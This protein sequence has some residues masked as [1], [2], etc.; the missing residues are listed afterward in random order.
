MEP[1]LTPA[2]MAEA[3]RRT[4][5]EGTAFETLVGRAGRAVARAVLDELGGAYGRRVVLACGTGN[6]GADGRVAA[7]ALS[8]R[9]VRCTVLDVA[10]GFDRAVAERAIRRADALVDAMYGTGFRGALEGD[11]AWFAERTATVAVPVV[12]ID[13]PS[14]IDGTTGA[15]AGPVVHATRTV[16]FAAWK[17]G[18]LAE[19]GRTCAG[20]VS[21]VDIGIDLGPTAAD[22]QAALVTGADVAAW[23]P[24][25][26]ADAHK[27]SAGPLLVVG[28]SPGMQGAP[29][30]AAAAALRAGSGIV[31]AATP[32]TDPEPR[33]DEGTGAPLE[34]QSSVT[35]TGAGADAGV[36]FGV[37]VV[38]RPLPSA[39]D[40]PSAG[41]LDD[42]GV[43]ALLAAAGRFGALVVGPGLGT[44]PS[45][46]PAV[47]RLIAECERPLLLDADALTALAGDPAPLRAR[48]EAGGAP[49]LLTP[50]EGEFARLD[51]P[52]GPDRL[53]AARRLA[54]ATGATVL[55]K[56][57]TTVVADPQGRVLVADTGG[58]WL[59]TAGTGDVLSGI[60][61][62]LLAAGLPPIRAGAA[63]AWLHGGAADL[64]GHT[65][66]V[67]G[68]LVAA[69]AEAVRLLTDR[70]VPSRAPRTDDPTP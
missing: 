25:R 65:C 18:L 68:D 59:A 40:G 20:A 4:I 28:G 17:P 12:A 66:L 41:S 33:R 3:D 44:A 46:G 36:P 7:D 50:H 13:I 31:W 21:V 48:A 47:R 58:P 10:G 9:G 67:A 60:A 14:G 29:I 6:N 51:A 30:L 2:E 37:E 61:G 15:A 11:A 35:G 38:R 63:A 5:A 1:I 52:V 55:L 62:S 53:A 32:T 43:D 34:L 54:A 23:W 42:A 45:V 70:R 8:A 22:P 26:D 64:A 49:V 27:W 56:G 39:P 24:T 19:L 16:T 69:L 57:P